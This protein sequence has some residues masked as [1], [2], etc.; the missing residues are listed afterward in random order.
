MVVPPDDR[1]EVAR[2]HFEPLAGEVDEEIL[3]YITQSAASVLQD[4][5]DAK[6][7]Q[8]QL[9][10]AL[11]AH[12]EEAGVKD[13]PSFI[14]GLVSAVWPEKAKPKAKA[15]SEAGGSDAKAAG[16]AGAKAKAKAEVSVEDDEVL[17]RIPNMILMYGGSVKPL[18]SGTVF[19]LLRGHRYGVVGHNGAGKTTLM[20]RVAVGDFAGMGKLKCYHLAHEGIL[21]NIDKQTPCNEYVATVAPDARTVKKIMDD[22]GFSAEMFAKPIGELSGGW[23]MRL[24]LGCAALQNADVYLLDEPTNH[25]DTVAIAWLQDYLV[26]EG[27][28]RTALIISHDAK[29]LNYACTDI[30][31][32]TGDGKLVYY[33]GNFD[34]FRA[35]SHID[36]KDAEEVLQVRG[37]KGDTGDSALDGGVGEADNA[38]A[39]EPASGEDEMKFPI[40][41]KVD[42]LGSL[43][44]PLATVTNLNFR[45]FEDSPYVLKDVT[46]KLTMNSRIGVIGRNG[47]GKSTLLNLL[48]GELLPPED[49]TGEVSCVW[50]HRNM[51]LAYIAQ[52]HFVHLGDYFGSSPLHYMQ[53]RFRH[54]WDAESQKRLMMPQ[55]PEEDQYRKEMAIKHGKRGKEVENLM[56]RQKKGKTILYEVKWRGL[57]DAK[58]NTYEPL[59]KLRIMGVEKMAAAL[60]DRIACAES[61]LRPLTTREIVSHLEPFGITE[62][63]CCHRTIGGFS[64]GQKSKMMI[65]AAMWTKPHVIAFDEP[66][67]YL[68][69]ATVAN[70]ARAIKLFRGGTIVIT[71][72]EDFVKETS[73]EIWRV[74]DGRVRVQDLDGNVRLG[75]AQS[76][77]NALVASA[78]EKDKLVNVVK[79]EEASAAGPTEAEKALM[80]YL[81]ARKKMGA[82][83]SD[84]KIP[85]VDLKAP[86]GTELL[87][88]TEFILNQGRRYGLVGR[89]GIG[90]STLLREI[91]HYKMEKFPK[92]LKVLM[93]EQEIV[94]NDLKP[95]EWV[96]SSNIEDKMLRE[97]HR[98]LL[99]SDDP[100][101]AERLKAIDDRLIEIGA[102]DAEARTNVI[103]RG[104][105]FTDELLNTPTS[106]LS[107]GWRMRVSLASSLIN[108]PELLLLDEPTNHL[109]FPAV[110]WLE[111]YLQSFPNTAIVV[112]HDRSFLN[113]VCSDTVLL[114]GR[115]LSYYKGD[116]ETFRQTMATNRLAQQRAYDTQQKEIAHIMEFINKHDE[117]PKI[118]AQKASKQKII[119]KMEKIEDPAL[120][121]ADSSSLSIRFP[122][123]GALPKNELV[124]LD[125]VS[126]GYPGRSK[127]FEKATLNLD[128][129]G[130]IGILGANGAGKST[131]L[132]VMQGKLIPTKGNMTVNRN[133]RVGVFAQHHV[134]SLDL[135]S[136]CVD[137]VQ[138]KYPG[139]SDQDARNIL[140]R[141]GING[142]MALRSISSLSGG[143]KSRVALAI[144]THCLP[145]L[146]FLDEP[147]NHLDM[148][149]IDALIDAIKGFGGAVVMVSHDQ[150]FLS[151]VATEFWSV[152]NGK[153]QKFHDIAEAKAASYKGGS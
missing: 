147:T 35:K 74:E 130:R 100:A 109:D 42:G 152:A 51:R 94:G 108:Q 23:K 80:L 71:H 115:K 140:G 65:A 46:V 131:L 87:V 58:Q 32:F 121:F 136:N 33:E 135:K 2:K 70:L 12:L 27:K 79:R 125:D 111:E 75:A 92:N 138:A 61:A 66:T 88:N 107:G 97:E 29:F 139:L 30:I 128:I 106:E 119:D 78:K 105:Q 153:V 36:G 143:Q 1:E 40:P 112:S 84:I 4:A 60:D 11:E 17:V 28:Q 101:N 44:K 149:T 96:L 150:Y 49:E 13:I 18:L 45:Y 104:L 21:D 81:A 77:K 137:C 102:T 3:D 117:R 48:A 34:A 15:K 116:Y 148:E 16:K 124:R 90:K 76:Q 89:N 110:L 31:H 69:F 37:R 95:V 10:E 134:E 98:Q 14:K 20:S 68:D 72:N 91:G 123:P 6:E 144:I 63:M 82:P 22:V 39:P 122:A 132:K 141:F 86:D 151:Q 114:N 129:N 43:S 83:K 67:N 26:R 99:E 8:E 133:M 57:D 53:L 56:S 120:T 38:T 25:L 9:E 113:N 24:A 103:L 7:A 55:T 118:V 93:V 41:G 64:A 73:D 52:H 59:S 5:E 146:I 145:H 62:N 47:A 19:E 54:G 85:N 126:F 127:L 50:R 142:D